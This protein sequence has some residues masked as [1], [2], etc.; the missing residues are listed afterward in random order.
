MVEIKRETFSPPSET[1]EN[2]WQDYILFL[3]Q[4]LVPGAPQLLQ[5][6][7]HPKEMGGGGGRVN[8]Q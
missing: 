6:E 4:D 8:V 2:H 5:A 7:E 1:I 3:N